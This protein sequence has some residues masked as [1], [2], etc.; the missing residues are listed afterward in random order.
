MNAKVFLLVT[1]TFVSACEKQQDSRMS[2]SNSEDVR[3]NGTVR[4]HESIARE[5]ISIGHS[6]GE[7]VVQ[8]TNTDDAVAFAAKVD[9]FVSR[10]DEISR[11]LDSVGPFSA[12]L[13]DAILKELDIKGRTIADLNQH[14]SA[15]DPLNSE[16]A[17]VLGDAADKY[18]PAWLSVAMRAGLTYETKSAQEL[19]SH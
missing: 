2:G 15:S 12:G 5:I 14:K 10:L 4:S 1:F 11:E 13:R 19:Q 18:F 9:S 16:A 7:A 6:F 17:K 8:V 3:A